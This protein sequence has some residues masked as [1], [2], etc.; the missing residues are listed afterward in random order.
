VW[1]STVVGLTTEFFSFCLIGLCNVHFYVTVLHVYLVLYLGMYSIEYLAL[2]NL[3]VI[4]L[5]HDQGSATIPRST[6]AAT[7]RCRVHF[8]TLAQFAETQADHWPDDH[9][10]ASVWPMSHPT[11][12]QVVFWWSDTLVFILTTRGHCAST[13]SPW[14]HQHVVQQG[15]TC[16]WKVAHIQDFRVSDSE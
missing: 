11:F 7:T 3:Y 6:K 12:S 13:H 16:T 9:C 5:E 15:G 14:C 8:D 2:L 10:P 4:Y 1:A